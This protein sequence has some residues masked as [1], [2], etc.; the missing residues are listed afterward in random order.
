MSDFGN[1]HIDQIL[2]RQEPDD[3]SIN[4]IVDTNTHTTTT[5]ITVDPN[6][7]EKLNTTIPALAKIRAELGSRTSVLYPANYT[8]AQR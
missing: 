8:N 2:L 3:L 5:T 7:L 6:I 4:I 1:T